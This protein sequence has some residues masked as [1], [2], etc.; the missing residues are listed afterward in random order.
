MK[1]ENALIF[2]AKIAT[3][4]TYGAISFALI[5]PMFSILLDSMH[6]FLYGRWIY[7]YFSPIKYHIVFIL[8]FL[9][10]IP[11]ILIIEK[12]STNPFRYIFGGIMSS[13]VAWT[14]LEEGT[15]H[16]LYAWSF[17]WLNNWK[18]GLFFIAHGAVTGI[19]F[20]LTLFFLKLRKNFANSL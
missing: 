16:S 18:L 19:L 7:L 20:T 6:P 15:S 1:F 13:I 10:G 3:L 11:C 4:A 9:F 17:P 5:M 12:F 14:I 2:C 8:C